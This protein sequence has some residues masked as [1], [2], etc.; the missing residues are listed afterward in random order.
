MQEKEAKQQKM[1]NFAFK[2]NWDG[3]IQYLE[4]G[5]DFIYVCWQSLEK[6]Q[7]NSVCYGLPHKKPVRKP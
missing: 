5:A 2:S 6:L 4:V 3:I 1:L 7:P